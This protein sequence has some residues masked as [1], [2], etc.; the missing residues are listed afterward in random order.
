M[1]RLSQQRHYKIIKS[2]LLNCMMATNIVRHTQTGFNLQTARPTSAKTASFSLLH[3]LFTDEE[4]V[5]ERLIIIVPVAILC[6][7]GD[8]LVQINSMT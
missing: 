6:L 5:M 7:C 1:L 2:S 4:I 8:L 3:A